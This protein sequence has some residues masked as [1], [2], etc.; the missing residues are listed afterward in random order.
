MK[1]QKYVLVSH[2]EFNARTFLFKIK[3]GVKVKVGDVVVCETM[4]GQDVGFVQEII[5][6]PK[7]L[8]NEL[9][10]KFEA[11]QPLKEIIFS[12]PRDIYNLIINTKQVYLSRAKYY[13]ETLVEELKDVERKLK[14]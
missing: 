9:V 4:K 10:G 14:G 2:K 11:Y 5:Q 7:F 12:M 1:N 8:E 3:K 13:A 6:S